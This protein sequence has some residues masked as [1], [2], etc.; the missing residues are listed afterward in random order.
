MNI[1]DHAEKFLGTINQGWKDSTG[2]GLQVASFC[3]TPFKGVNSYLS[4]GLNRHVLS[5]SDTKSIR[6]E[7]I[8]AVNDGF[9]SPTIVNNILF[10][11]ESILDDHKALLRGQVVKLPSELASQLGFDALYCS[12]PI[13]WDDDFSE[14][15]GSKPPVIIVLLIPIFNQEADFIHQ[16]GWSK[17]EGL[18][19]D[20]NPDLFSMNREPVV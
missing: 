11:C 17:F 16:N 7:L 1:I 20:K 18:L 9:S 19:D 14:F 2:S 3:N 15:S 4:L 8:M 12:I 6:H 5:I 10:V 13:F